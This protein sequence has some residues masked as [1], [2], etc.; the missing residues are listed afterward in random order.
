[1]EK[2]KLCFWEIIDDHQKQAEKILHRYRVSR[3]HDFYTANT[4]QEFNNLLSD[5]QKTL[6]EHEMFQHFK[7]TEGYNLML[8]LIEHFRKNV[9]LRKKFED[10][11]AVLSTYIE[12]LDEIKKIIKKQT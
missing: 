8:E 6:I 12:N 4:I 2:S 1:M 11:K 7:E 9:P 10:T 5:T 3:N